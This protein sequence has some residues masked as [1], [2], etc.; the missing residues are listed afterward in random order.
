MSALRRAIVGQF[1]KPTGAVGAI[2][3]AVMASRPSNRKRNRWTIG[4]LE[5]NPADHV[6]ELG[7]GPGF[8]LALA[9]DKAPKGFVTGVDHSPVMILMARK[10][11]D[12]ALRAG[13]C[14]LVIG[15]DSQ[16]CAFEDA[17]DAVYS[18]N[19]VQFLPDT[20]RYF[21]RAFKA[22][23]KG[24]R[25]ATTYQPRGAN[26]TDAQADAMAVQCADLANKAGFSS[27][28]IERLALDG[29]GAV[30]ALALK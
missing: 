1:K 11:V 3:G 23:K 5:I 8:A 24:G 20:Q 14:N 29:A 6:F 21:S 19:V 4:L 18:A 12:R 30:C 28:R 17:L 22:L 13:R 27:V 9:A 16:L 15:D 2:A 10:R 7:C 25:M 26:P